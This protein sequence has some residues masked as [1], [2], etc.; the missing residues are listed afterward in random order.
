MLMLSLFEFK[1]LHTSIIVDITS[2]SKA[3]SG[4]WNPETSNA[5]TYTENGL[6]S[7]SLTIEINNIF[8]LMYF[9]LFSEEEGIISH[10]NQETK[11]LT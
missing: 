7:R 3:T 10:F 4:M 2:G 6:V 1:T 8:I 5:H 11:A 9:G